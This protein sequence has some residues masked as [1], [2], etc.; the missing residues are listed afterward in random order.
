MSISANGEGQGGAPFR[1]RHGLQVSELET[2]PFARAGCLRRLGPFLAS[3]VRGNAHGG[4]SHN[5]TFAPF[6]GG[7]RRRSGERGVEIC[8]D[9]QDVCAGRLG[10]RLEMRP[11][12]HAQMLAGRGA[13]A[14]AEKRVELPDA[15]GEHQRAG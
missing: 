8:G 3:P 6:V 9:L 11:D 10:E 1:E 12:A 14:V 13:A 7:K 5:S 4:G 2:R 15:I